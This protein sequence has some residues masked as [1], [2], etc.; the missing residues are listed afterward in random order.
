VKSLV[1]REIVVDKLRLAYEGLFSAKELYNLIDGWFFEKGYDKRENRNTEIVRPEGKYIEIELEPWKKVTDY[2]R[3][4]IKVRIIIED[5]KE[6]VVEK[7][8]HKVKLNHGKL[9]FVFDAYLDTDYENKWEGKPVFYFLRTIFDK[10]IYK[11][12]TIGFETGVKDDLNQ[13]HT[14]I[15]AFLN[16]YR[17]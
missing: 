16:L 4:V 15:K 14:Q 11:P 9:K 7:D 2:A 12:F 8:H 10:Y 3:N 5:L 6:V 17:F 1:E 13:L